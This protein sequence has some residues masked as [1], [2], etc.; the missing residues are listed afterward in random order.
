MSYVQH[1]WQNDE[2]IT[3]A[4]LNNIEEGIAA[5][6]SGGGYDAVI[7]IYHDDNS[8]HD[9]EISIVSGSY[10]AI[11]EKTINNQ[12]PVVLALVWDDI[13]G[14]HGATTMTSLYGWPNSDYPNAD[15]IFAVKMF[16]SNT[17]SPASY[18]NMWALMVL[19]TSNDEVSA[20]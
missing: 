3:A 11:E 20:Y 13:A 18:S 10:S 19:W 14:Y 8:S 1:E 15:F 17:H 6:G 9:Y 16:S 7:S 4:K 12:P 2:L 5:G